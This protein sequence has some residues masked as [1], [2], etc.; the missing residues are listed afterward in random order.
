M[1]NHLPDEVLCQNFKAMALISAYQISK[2][3]VR[4]SKRYNHLPDE[5]WVVLNMVYIIYVLCQNS[6]QW[7]FELISRYWNE[8]LDGDVQID[9]L[10]SSYISLILTSTV[11]E[12]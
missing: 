12:Q 7:L 8:S 1:N 3:Y 11:D 10:N 6:K 9:L 5:V 2:F 4:T